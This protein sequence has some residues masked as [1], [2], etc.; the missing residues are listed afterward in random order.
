VGKKKKVQRSA[1]HEEKTCFCTKRSFFS[2]TCLNMSLFFLSMERDNFL[3][4]YLKDSLA[5]GKLDEHSA[6]LRLLPTSSETLGQPN[7]SMMP[8]PSTKYQ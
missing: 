7:Y 6:K 1:D 3:I 4:L 2:L 5:V 8:F